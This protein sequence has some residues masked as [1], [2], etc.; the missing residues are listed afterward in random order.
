MAR[1]SASLLLHVASGYHCPPTPP[2][3]ST[4]SVRAARPDPPRPGGSGAAAVE[5]GPG[6]SGAGRLTPPW[7]ERGWRCWA[8]VCSPGLGAPTVLGAGTPAVLGAGTLRS[9]SPPAVPSGGAGRGGTW[10]VRK[11]PCGSLCPSPREREQDG[12]APQVR[13]E[14]RCGEPHC[15]GPAWGGGGTIGGERQRARGQ[16]GQFRG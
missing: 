11:A 7:A 12:T 10:Q 13:A 9:H 2:G 16:D 1:P 14:P 4:A 3:T 5:Q 6:Q 8:C 15:A